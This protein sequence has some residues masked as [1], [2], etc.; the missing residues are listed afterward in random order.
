MKKNTKGFTTKE[1]SMKAAP[2]KPDGLKFLKQ[3]GEIRLFCSPEHQEMFRQKDPNIEKAIELALEYGRNQGVT[4]GNIIAQLAADFNTERMGGMIG[5][6]AD[7]SFFKGM[8]VVDE[9]MMVGTLS[10]KISETK[11]KRLRANNVPPIS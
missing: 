7:P 1:K 9:R 6:K 2:T 8:E 11:Y 4:S 3:E 10:I 5:E